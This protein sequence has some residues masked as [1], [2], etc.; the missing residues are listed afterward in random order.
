MLLLSFTT[1][2][3][4]LPVA[5]LGATLGAT[6]PQDAPRKGCSLIKYRF[7]LPNEM[8]AMLE[9]RDY[10]ENILMPLL[11]QKCSSSIKLF[12]R[13][14]KSAELPVA[15]RVTLARTELEL[16]TSMLKLPTTQPSFNQLR[17]QPL[18]FLTQ[19]QE[20]L[21]GCVGTENPSHHSSR[22]LRHWLQKLEVAM[23][24]ETTRCLEA[25]VIPHIFQVT[26]DLNC[27]ALQEECS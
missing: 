2:L 21:K 27:A 1:L 14:W 15:D 17:L 16:V 19:A 7:L 12:H 25:S 26:Y 18:A 3:A 22:K 9:M 5:T 8:K 13:N 23:K 6:L 10:F 24:T 11:D 4:L 20:D